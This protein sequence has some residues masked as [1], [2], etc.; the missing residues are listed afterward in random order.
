MKVEYLGVVTKNNNVNK[1]PNYVK[2]FVNEEHDRV[3]RY[4]EASDSNLLDVSA[5]HVNPLYSHMA[6]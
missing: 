5:E 6:T 2:T 3:K 1:I 4:C